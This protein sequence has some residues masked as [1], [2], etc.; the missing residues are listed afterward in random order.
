MRR[1]AKLTL[2]APAG[3]ALVQNRANALPNEAVWPKRILKLEN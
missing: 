2:P 3:E 1:E